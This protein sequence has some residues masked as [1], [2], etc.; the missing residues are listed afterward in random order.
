M[1]PMDCAFCLGRSAAH[2]GESKD[3]N[4]YEDPHVG[5]HTGEWYET[6]FALWEIGYS[7][8][9]TEPDGVPWYA[10]HQEEEAAGPVQS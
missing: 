9:A 3:Q 4:P 7:V 1:I 5:T 6:D 2:R 10:H 8:G